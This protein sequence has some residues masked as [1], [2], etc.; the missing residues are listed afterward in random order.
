MDV[1][2]LVL[3]LIVVVVGGLGTLSGAQAGA[4]LVGPADTFGKVLVPQFAL[5]LIFAIMALVLLFR[6]SGLLGR[7]RVIR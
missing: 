1:D 7:I 3:S 5:F 2:A 4:A 6:P